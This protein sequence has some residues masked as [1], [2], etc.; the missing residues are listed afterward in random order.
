MDINRF[1][2]ENHDQFFRRVMV[3]TN[4][5]QRDLKKYGIPQSTASVLCGIG[6]LELK[7]YIMGLKILLDKVC[8]EYKPI[9]MKYLYEACNEKDKS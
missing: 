2:F 5:K 3:F 1:D 8:D 6:V 4:T 9:V 7:W